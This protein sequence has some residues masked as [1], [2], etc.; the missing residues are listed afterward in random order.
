MHVHGV[1]GCIFRS[2]IWGYCA[3]SAVKSMYIV[4]IGES[5][6]GLRSW[7]RGF[8]NASPFNFQKI[9]EY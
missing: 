6:G 4:S 5:R 7:L 2:G 1:L 9:K 3:D 8:Q